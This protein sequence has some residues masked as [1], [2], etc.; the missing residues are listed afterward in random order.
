LLISGQAIVAMNTRP[1]IK[2]QARFTLVVTYI[3]YNKHGLASIVMMMY[4]LHHLIMDY[5]YDY[6]CDYDYD[7]DYDC[8]YDD[9][10]YVRLY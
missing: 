9:D 4:M 7:Y 3:L 6:D 5:D 8:D 10:L 2:T 1:S